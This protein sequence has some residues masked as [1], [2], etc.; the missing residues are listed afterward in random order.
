MI[1]FSA[2]LNSSEV[3]LTPGKACLC[4]AHEG[5][6]LLAYAGSRGSAVATAYNRVREVQE[7][8]Q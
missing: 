5:W 6:G 4:S 3:V 2:G 8:L 1:W 7:A